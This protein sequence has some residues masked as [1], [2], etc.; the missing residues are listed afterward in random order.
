MAQGRA[1][2]GGGGLTGLRAPAAAALRAGRYTDL[3]PAPP[4]PIPC[5]PAPRRGPAAR[6]ATP[7][8]SR[9]LR[10]TVR[11][12]PVLHQP[13]TRTSTLA[14]RREVK[15][16]RGCVSGLRQG[17]R[18]A[19]SAPGRGQA[20]VGGVVTM[21]GACGRGR[22][23][24]LRVGTALICLVLHRLGVLGFPKSCRQRRAVF[25]LGKGTENCVHI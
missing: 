22:C 5:S 6:L 16:E 15:G 18:G 14:G 1:L 10:R 9:L 25:H 17:R 12:A 13:A 19:C 11:E 2:A 8:P 3:R 23:F 7:S 4:R 20:P 21:G 24:V